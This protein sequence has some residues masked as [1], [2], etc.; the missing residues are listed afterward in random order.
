MAGQLPGRSRKASLAGRR[1]RRLLLAAAAMV[2]VAVLGVLAY[3]T[4]EGSG[5]LVYGDG[6]PHGC[7]TPAVM[8]WAYEAIN[9]DVALDA[10]LPVDNPAWLTDCPKHGAGTADS[11]VVSSDAV[12]LAGW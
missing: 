2:A 8:G 4:S 10:R 5:T 3:V 7:A 11:E 6:V 12:R 9:Y 1:L